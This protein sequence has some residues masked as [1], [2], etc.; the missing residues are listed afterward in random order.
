MTKKPAE[1][2]L[3]E[4]NPGD[5]RLIKEMLGEV[6]DARFHLDIATR[7]SAGLESLAQKEPDV[8]LLDLGLPD[9]QGLETL[10]SVSARAPTTPTVVFTGLDD[11]T[12]ALEAVRR[13]AQDYLV[14]G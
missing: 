3:I 6:P 14:K 5:A 4:D 13:G 12:T 10:A 9:S 7:L 1:V 2:L 8:I 11:E